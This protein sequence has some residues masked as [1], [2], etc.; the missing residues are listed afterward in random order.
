[1]PTALHLI[2]PKSLKAACLAL[3][4]TA[5]KGCALPLGNVR[6]GVEL[7]LDENHHTAGEGRPSAGTNQCQGLIINEEE[8]YIV[9][10]TETRPSSPCCSEKYV[11]QG[12]NLTC[13][14]T[15]CVPRCCVQVCFFSDVL[16]PLLLLFFTILAS[17]GC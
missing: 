16:A 17:A 12:N 9:V 8:E 3:F 14:F 4:Y 13:G 7:N 2:Y 15:H 1:M 11:Q 5:M 6:K 10:P